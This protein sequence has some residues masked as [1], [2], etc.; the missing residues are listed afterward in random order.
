MSPNW[1]ET[2]KQAWHPKVDTFGVPFDTF[3]VSNGTKS[4]PGLWAFRLS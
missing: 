4:G 2:Q 3:Q 1:T